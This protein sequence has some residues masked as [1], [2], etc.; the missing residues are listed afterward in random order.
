MFCNRYR[1]AGR[2]TQNMGS[3]KKYKKGCLMVERLGKVY[4]RW[5]LANRRSYPII[6]SPW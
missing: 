3:M 5:K 4:L 6:I 2:V 1:L